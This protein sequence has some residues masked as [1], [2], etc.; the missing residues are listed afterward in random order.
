MSSPALAFDIVIATRNRQAILPLS[1]RTMLTQSVL[2]QRLIVV[3][4]SDDHAEVERAVCKAVSDHAP[5]LEVQVIRCEPGSSRQRNIGLELVGSPVVFFPDDDVLW[6][7]GVAEAIMRIYSRDSGETVG[8]VTTLDSPVPPPGTLDLSHPQ[9]RSAIRGEPKSTARLFP[10]FPS[11]GLALDPIRE[12][13]DWMTTWGAK[14][15]PPWLS[16]ED[17]ELCGPVIGYKMTFRSDLIRRIGGFDERLGR[18][19]RHEDIDASI[20]CLNEGLNVVARR[21]KVFHCR[22]GEGRASGKEWG[23][24]SILS[25]TYV[26]CK[27]S[28]PG[29]IARRRVQ[30]YLYYQLF[31]YGLQ[32]RS[33]FGRER[34]RAALGALSHARQLIA[35]SNADVVTRYAEARRCLGF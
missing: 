1:L 21:A 33:R 5:S 12:D 18:Y 16:D 23:M 7:P 14:T 24:T 3:D 10:S 30:K 22:Y 31:R 35:A 17:A 15:A 9:H 29:S 34:F 4:A 32:F 8:C 27:N 11:P 13:G 6:L 19:A 20:R 28:P 25:R 26:V 2:P